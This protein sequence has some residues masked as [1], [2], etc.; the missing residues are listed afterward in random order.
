M[1]IT[2]NFSVNEMQCKCSNCG[3]TCAMDREFMRKLQ[4]V[5]DDF[6]EELNVNS[7]FR[8]KVHNFNIGGSLNSWHTKGLASDLTPTNYTPSNQ[9]AKLKR[10]YSCAKKQFREVILYKTFVHMADE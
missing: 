5:R 2:E 10:L 3:H 4:L 9:K 8:C 6:G 1:M 7:G